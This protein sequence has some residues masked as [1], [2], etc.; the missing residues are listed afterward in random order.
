[1]QGAQVLSPK[2]SRELMVVFLHPMWLFRP[3]L[4]DV[5]SLGIVSK[6]PLKDLGFI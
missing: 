1:M 4:D 2:Q 6:K 5:L 3:F